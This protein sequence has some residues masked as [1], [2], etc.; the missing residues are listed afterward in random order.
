MTS[1]LDIHWSVHR[2]WVKT[3][4]NVGWKWMST[5]CMHLAEDVDISSLLMPSADWATATT[6][7]RTESWLQDHRGMEWV[8]NPPCQDSPW[9]IIIYLDME[10]SHSFEEGLQLQWRVALY[11]RFPKQE[12]MSTLTTVPDQMRPKHE[13][14]PKQRGVA[15][16]EYPSPDSPDCNRQLLKHSCWNSKFYGVFTYCHLCM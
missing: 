13:G 1:P 9:P 7:H 4:G 15:S 11:P 5:D 12:E 2:G 6:T 16:K 10:S 8:S 14:M 3:S